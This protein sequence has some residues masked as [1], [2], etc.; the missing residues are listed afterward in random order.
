MKKIA[1]LTCLEATGVCSGAA[2]F[3]AL[4]QRTA[5][6]QPYVEIEVEVLG[7]FHCNGCQCDYDLDLEYDEKMTTLIDL[8]P[9]VIHVGKCT[10]QKGIECKVITRMVHR[11]EANGITV[12]RGTH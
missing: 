11:F 9:D 7:F 10:V 1:I 12:V 3:K 2:C 4:N 5:F 8:K 6:F